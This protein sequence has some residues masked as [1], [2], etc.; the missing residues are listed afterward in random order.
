M[1]AIRDALLATYPHLP[2]RRHGFRKHPTGER[3]LGVIA[4]QGHDIRRAADSQ[5]T[6]RA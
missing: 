2:N 3:D 4:R 5:S 6:R 1:P